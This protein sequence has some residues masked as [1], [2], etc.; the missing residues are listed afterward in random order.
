MSKLRKLSRKLKLNSV[1]SAILVH[2]KRKELAFDLIRTRVATDRQFADD[3]LHA[4]GDT[5][6]KDIREIAEKTVMQDDIIKNQEA[7]KSYVAEK[8]KQ[9]D[10][11]TTIIDDGESDGHGYTI[12]HTDKLKALQVKTNEGCSVVDVPQEEL[13][14]A[15]EVSSANQTERLTQAGL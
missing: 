9:L 8:R 10:G 3:V 1:N 7:I 13:L 6:P 5:L 11:F 4:A 15:L 12:N 2:D 14:K